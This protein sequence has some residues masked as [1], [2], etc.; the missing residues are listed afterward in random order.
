MTVARRGKH[1]D[2][3]GAANIP[4]RRMHCQQQARLRGG[5]LPLLQLC[6]VSCTP[7]LPSCLR[8]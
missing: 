5:S 2:L 3:P 1:C 7:S 6:T 8:L 4:I